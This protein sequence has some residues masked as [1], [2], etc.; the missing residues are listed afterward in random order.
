ME[1]LIALASW[2]VVKTYYGAVSVFVGF[3]TD[4]GP[5]LTRATPA[6]NITAVLVAVTLITIVLCYKI[7]LRNKNTIATS[8]LFVGFITDFLTSLQGT[9]ATTIS[10]VGER[11]ILQWGL[12]IFL[13]TAS[14]AC[15]ILIHQVLEGTGIELQLYE[16]S[17]LRAYGLVSAAHSLMKNRLDK[18]LVR[19]AFA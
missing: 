13:S 7:T 6:H 19:D 10:T 9:A 15:P 5:N 12:V 4:L 17:S 11:A 1:L 16:I 14:T 3:N 2:D 8:I 18:R